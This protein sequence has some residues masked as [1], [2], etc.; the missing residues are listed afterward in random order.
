MTKNRTIYLDMDGVLADFDLAA[1]N[2]L[3][4]SDHDLLTTQQQG[5]WPREQ[6]NLIKTHNPRFYRSLPKTLLAD[7]LVDLAR[8]F[9]DN[10]N[11]NLKIL[12]AIPKDNDMPWAFYDKILWQQ[13]HYSDIPVMFGPYS[14]DKH[15]HCLPN[16]I[17]I[18][19]RIDNCNDWTNAK[20]IALR[21]HNN[22]E[23]ILSTLKKLLIQTQ[24]Q[25]SA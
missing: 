3:K 22:F 5:R 1:K 9:R 20:G 21:V 8:K 7:P 23:E 10:Y 2:F 16:D 15:L 24:I 19:D 17:L 13:E 12:T 25:T 18:D 14:K 4:A 11:W 6:W